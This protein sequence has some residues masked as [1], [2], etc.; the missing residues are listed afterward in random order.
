MIKEYLE[1]QRSV[2]GLGARTI[3]E[4]GKDLREWVSWAK[5]RG[6]TWRTTR[7]Q[8]VDDWTR[9]MTGRGLMP[10]T[11]KRRV[12]CLRCV[13]RWA[14]HEGLLE[15]NPAQW[16]QTPKAK[17]TLPEVVDVAMVDS[18]LLNFGG[19]L[20]RMDVEHGDIRLLVAMLIETGCRISEALSMRWEDIDLSAKRVL[21]EGKGGRARYAYFGERVAREL[22]GKTAK[23]GLVW[24]WTDREAREVMYRTLGTEIP[25][26]HPHLLRHT[27]ATM[28]VERGMPLKTLS[29]LLGHKH[30]ATTEIYTHVA[31]STLGRQ[32]QQ[33]SF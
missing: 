4:Y 1:Y 18:W 10:K 32:Y 26:V 8:D 14:V 2:K 28:M 31:E 5:G 23:H 12:S 24:R 25:G 27:F 22:C 3:E 19:N 20:R 33:Y 7:K 17:E 16:C 6:L 30:A 11:I 13:Y 15:L 21:V 29:V 9:W